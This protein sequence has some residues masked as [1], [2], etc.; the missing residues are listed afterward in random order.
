MQIKKKH[1]W[2]SRHFL[3]DCQGLFKMFFVYLL[4]PYTR[5]WTYAA[6][7]V[8]LNITECYCKREGVEISVCAPLP[9]SEGRQLAWVGDFYIFFDPQPTFFGTYKYGYV[10]NCVKTVSLSFLFLPDFPFL[11][12]ELIYATSECPK[13]GE[14]NE[15]AQISFWSRVVLSACG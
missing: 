2:R 11:D 13:L 14:T 15:K 4:S 7:R 12:R 6:Q 5:G 3:A 1:C 9:I 10:S 8:L